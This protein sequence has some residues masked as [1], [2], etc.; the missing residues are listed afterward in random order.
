MDPLNLYIEVVGGVG[1]SNP[2]FLSL[3]FNEL[4]LSAKDK[5]TEEDVRIAIKK[6]APSIA[7][8]VHIKLNRNTLHGA[9]EARPDRICVSIQTSTKDNDLY[10]VIFAD[11]EIPLALIPLDISGENQSHWNNTI[12]II[13]HILPRRMREEWLGDLIEMR[14]QMLKEGWPRLWVNASTIGRLILLGWALIKIKV[15]DALSPEKKKKS[16]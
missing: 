9:M 5:P 7:R 12:A 2:H 13:G 4:I 14:S 1:K 8:T 15:T 3:L 10:S 16:S 11:D 6:V